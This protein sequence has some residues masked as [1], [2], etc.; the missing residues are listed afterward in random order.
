[1]NQTFWLETWSCCRVSASG[2]GT[3]LTW[4]KCERVNTDTKYRRW[5]LCFRN[6]FF[7]DTKRSIRRQEINHTAETKSKKVHQNKK[8]VLTLLATRIQLLKWKETSRY[9]EKHSERCYSTRS[10]TFYRKTFCNIPPGCH[11]EKE[12]TD[13]SN[14]K[15]QILYSTYRPWDGKKNA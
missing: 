4:G 14:S 5:Q 2:D 8:H 1:M 15:I 9:E 13:T 11:V 12:R 7:Y 10:I 6:C 3:T